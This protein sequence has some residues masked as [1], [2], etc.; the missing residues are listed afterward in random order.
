MVI[1]VTGWDC[2]GG[3]CKL[4]LEIEMGWDLIWDLREKKT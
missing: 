4:W 3:L 1:F 2:R